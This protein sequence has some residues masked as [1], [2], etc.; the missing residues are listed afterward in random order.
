MPGFGLILD[1]MGD[2]RDSHSLGPRRDVIEDRGRHAG[3]IDP[4][5]KFGQEG[6]R[7]L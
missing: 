1:R 4:I 6:P 3:R 5:D 7:C 2:G